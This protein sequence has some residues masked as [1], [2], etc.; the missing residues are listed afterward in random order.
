MFT[1]TNQYQSRRP[2]FFPPQTTGQVD[3]WQNIPHVI[4]RADMEAATDILNVLGQV[5]RWDNI[6]F[7]SVEEEWDLWDQHVVCVGGHYK[8]DRLL[9]ACEPRLVRLENNS[10]FVLVDSA[11]TFQIDGQTDRAIIYKAV[12]PQTGRT[13]ILVMGL[14]ALGT[15][16]AGYFLRT[17]A[18]DF[19]KMFGSK[20]FCAVVSADLLQGKSSASLTSCYPKPGFMRRMTHPFVWVRRFRTASNGSA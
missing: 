4:G 7:L 2:D 9:E 12:Y 15:Q 5:G 6:N 19:G 10:R 17:H 1:P 11:Q 14:G 8:S 20:P 13:C 16:A 3:N 18:S